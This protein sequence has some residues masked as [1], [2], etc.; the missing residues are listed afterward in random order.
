MGKN[1]KAF[2]VLEPRI[3][4]DAQLDLVGLDAVGNVET[5]EAM[6]ALI[7][8]F[9]TQFDP[10]YQDGLLNLLRTEL[11]TGLEDVSELFTLLEGQE[12]TG[13]GEI[14]DI[15]ERVGLAGIQVVEEYRTDLNEIFER[16]DYD[17]VLDLDEDPDR[18]AM[19]SR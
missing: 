6:S 15:F 11:N 16:A 19:E 18:G 8:S 5:I 7:R 2:E 10:D 12:Q 13:F 14:E 9:E 1:E 3:L 17:T 4:L